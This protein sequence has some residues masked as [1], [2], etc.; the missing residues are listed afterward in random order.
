MVFFFLKL[1]C[2]RLAE[3][4]FC[5][6]GTSLQQV[7]PSKCSSRHGRGHAMPVLFSYFPNCS[8]QSV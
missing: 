3:K 1:S 4:G 5:P 7:T 8:Q 2:F 6:A